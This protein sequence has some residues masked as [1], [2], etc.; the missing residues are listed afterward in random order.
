MWGNVNDAYLET[1]VLTADPVGLVRMLYQGA[2]TAVREARAHLD[3]GDIAA[4]SAALNRACGILAELSSS[5]DHEMG[6]ELSQHL[7]QLYEY[8]QWRLVEANAKQ[9]G[10]PMTEVLSLLATLE[11]GWE[12]I[13]KAPAPTPAPA[14]API[15]AMPEPVPE[16]PA[17]NLA[18]Q[19]SYGAWNPEP[20]PGYNPWNQPS[21]AEPEPAPCY[22]SWSQPLP[23]EPEPSEAYSS[24]AWSF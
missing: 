18:P 24:H 11:E 14:L 23:P 7:E 10:E 2:S 22:N 6:G 20:A 21:P 12:G 1:R 17:W 13:Q 15:Q 5:L 19:S 4:R 3:S 8:M 9:S 16:T